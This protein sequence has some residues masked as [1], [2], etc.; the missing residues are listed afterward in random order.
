MLTSAPLSFPRSHGGGYAAVSARQ[1]IGAE[2]FSDT[3]YADTGDEYVLSA[4]S[5]LLFA[6]TDPVYRGYSYAARCIQGI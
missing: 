5:G 3:E 2:Y 1:G 4:L 6:G